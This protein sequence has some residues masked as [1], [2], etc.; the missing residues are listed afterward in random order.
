[1][2]SNVFPY[3]TVMLGDGAVAFVDLA[4]LLE[5]SMSRDGSSRLDS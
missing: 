5:R 2:I 1:V 3:C 4:I